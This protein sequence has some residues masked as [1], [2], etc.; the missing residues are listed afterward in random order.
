[1]APPVR[2]KPASKAVV[3][4]TPQGRSRR[5]NDEPEKDTR[6]GKRKASPV[7][8]SENDEDGNDENE[9]D[10]SMDIEPATPSREASL[11]IL[12][13]FYLFYLSIN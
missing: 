1:M 10:V 3:S 13:L 4:E 12:F 2:K 6:K 8:S 11:G 5:E 9:K 7:L